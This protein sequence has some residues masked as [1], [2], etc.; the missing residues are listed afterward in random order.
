MK[1]IDLL[2]GVFIGVAASVIG[3]F[4]FIEAFTNYGFMEGISTIRAQGNLGKGITL[5]A[6]LNLIVFFILLKFD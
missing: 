6:I 1:K 4:I 3:S 5:G 2:I